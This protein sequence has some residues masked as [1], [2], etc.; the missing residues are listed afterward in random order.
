MLNGTFTHIEKSRLILHPKLVNCLN[1]F[2]DFEQTFNREFVGFIQRISLIS[3]PVYVIK[4]N[5]NLYYIIAGWQGLK[6]A[7]L[8]DNELVPVIVL[9]EIPSKGILNTFLD[10]LIVTSLMATCR[11]QS[12]AILHDA[13]GMRLQN[14]PEY[15]KLVDKTTSP[16]KMAHY[17]TGETIQS[18]KTQVNEYSFFARSGNR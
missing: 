18:V 7:P 2:S 5:D 17:L 9:I 15:F 10:D 11:K 1:L 16:K 14:T 12:L 8:H 3:Q 6:F 13:I 4:T